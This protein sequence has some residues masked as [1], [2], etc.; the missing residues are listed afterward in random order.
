MHLTITKRHEL[1]TAR[2]VPLLQ[3]PV[4]SGD[5]WLAGLTSRKFRP[6]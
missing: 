1:L 5:A 6:L 3:S 2:R 4:L